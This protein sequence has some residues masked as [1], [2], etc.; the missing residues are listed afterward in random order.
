MQIAAHQSPKKLISSE[1]YRFK[2]QN[3]T[4]SNKCPYKYSTLTW[5]DYKKQ[6]PKPGYLNIACFPIQ[7][8]SLSASIM[9]NVMVNPIYNSIHG[10]VPATED[11]Y[12]E[13]LA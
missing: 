8:N 5:F 4:I 7:V 2:S 3:V 10:G 11:T 9:K 1:D 6:L 12:P 13:L